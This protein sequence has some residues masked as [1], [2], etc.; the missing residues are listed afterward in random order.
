M[1]R[2]ERRKALAIVL[3]DKLSNKQLLILDTVKLKEI[4]TKAMAD[5]FKKIGVEKKALLAFAERNETIEKSTSNLP[6]V[7]TLSVDYLNIADLLKYETLV[8]LK[9]GV[10]KLNTAK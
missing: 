6:R 1:N 7:K 2:K 10:E 9:D 3:S 4:K 8:L 5:V